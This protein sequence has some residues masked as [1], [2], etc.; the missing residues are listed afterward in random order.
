[1]DPRY[2]QAWLHLSLLR[3]EQGRF[4]EALGAADRAVALHPGRADT[5]TTR[6]IALRGLGRPAE[7]RE[8]VVRALVHRPNEPRALAELAELALAAGD[9]AGADAALAKLAAT[10]PRK[11]YA[12]VVAAYATRGRGAEAAAIVEHAT[13]AVRRD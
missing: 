3:A 7:A 6:A 13:L 11:A 10:A 2:V 9:D 4:E 12:S 1:V 8:A 5:L